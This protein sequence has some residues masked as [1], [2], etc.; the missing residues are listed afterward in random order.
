[1]LDPFDNLI[2]KKELNV[3]INNQ[4][5][6]SVS[7]VLNWKDYQLILFHVIQNAVKYNVIKGFIEINY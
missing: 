5:E 1:M 2:K 6:G 3:I 7:I 4:I